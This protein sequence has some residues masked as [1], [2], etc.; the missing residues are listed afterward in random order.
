MI[1]SYA[2][3]AGLIAALL[4]A[5][6]S[7]AQSQGTSQQQTPT[8]S[9]VANTPV[10]QSIAPPCTPA[11]PVGSG[12]RACQG[13][14]GFYTG[15]GATLPPSLFT[16]AH[17][18][19]ASYVETFYKPNP[20]AG[21]P[22]PVGP[23]FCDVAPTTFF[24][25]EVTTS[26]DSTS[27]G[28]SQSLRVGSTG[29]VI[30]R[31]SVNG[32]LSGT[33]E[34]G[35]VQGNIVSSLDRSLAQTE[36]QLTSSNALAIPTTGGAQACGSAAL[37]YQNLLASYTSFA[38]K[39]V[40]SRPQEDVNAE[41]L[42]IN[43]A[44]PNFATT[45][46]KANEPGFLQLAAVRNNVEQA[47]QSVLMCVATTTGLEN[48]ETIAGNPTLVKSM[49]LDFANRVSDCC[50]DHSTLNSCYQQNLTLIA[51]AQ[52]EA[53]F[54]PVQPDASLTGTCQDPGQHP[55]ACPNATSGVE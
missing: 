17:K 25:P 39:L 3:T 22:L 49:I 8:G 12:L 46:L 11:Q 55:H 21:I 5:Q 53:C 4:F 35:Y 27:C 10:I 45:A 28:K 20:Q 41:L 32:Q 23:T 31:R 33:L 9:A 52:S 2:C 18:Q 6:A 40:K 26:H 19:M 37:A 44:D 7:L 16:S 36:A 54:A 48:W 14:T 47:F 1:R 13:A 34:Q 42:Q 51:R 50:S 38:Q 43:A 24:G 29:I 15:T 30:D